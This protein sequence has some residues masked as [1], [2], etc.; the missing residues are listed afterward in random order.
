L[1]RFVAASAPILFWVI[2]MN[3]VKQG[4]IISFFA[5]LFLLQ[6]ISQLLPMHDL[7]MT[8]TMSQTFELDSVQISSPSLLFATKVNDT[9]GVMVNMTS[10]SHSM[11]SENCDN[12]CQSMAKDCAEIMCTSLVYD[13]SIKSP[14]ITAPMQSVNF[15]SLAD[16]IGLTFTS[17]YRPPIAHLS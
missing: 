14:L 15:Y 5:A 10:S 3:A 13:E 17:L 2:N 4:V 9:Q 6:S 12:H 11:M 7:T 1:K 8:Q 16:Y